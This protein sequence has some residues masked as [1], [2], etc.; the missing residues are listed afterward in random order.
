ME[1]VI[2]KLLRDYRDIFIYGAGGVAKAVC[3]LLK[4]F[5]KNKVVH[6]VVT[7]V[8]KK[9][10]FVEEYKV[11]DINDL[12]AGKYKTDALIVVAMMLSSAETVTRL[13][14]SEMCIRDRS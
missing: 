4:E 9:P 12:Q 8:K 10:P 2:E 7:D 1:N 11:Y 5:C 14:G 13:V 6:I 3:R